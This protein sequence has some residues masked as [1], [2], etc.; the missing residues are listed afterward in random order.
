VCRYSAAFGADDAVAGGGGGGGAAAN[1]SRY[2]A[3]IGA[4]GTIVG[5][6]ALCCWQAARVLRFDTLNRARLLNAVGALYKL[7]S[8]LPMDA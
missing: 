4:Y 2:G 5:G 1:L 6:H 3:T 7:N 8:V